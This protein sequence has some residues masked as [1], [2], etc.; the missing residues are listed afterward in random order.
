MIWVNGGV[1]LTPVTRELGFLD[2]RLERPAA[3]LFAA[4][5]APPVRPRPPGAMLA[6]NEGDES[7]ADRIRD[8]V[9]ALTPPQEQRINT[10]FG[11]WRVPRTDGG[12]K[13]SC[14]K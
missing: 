7:H 12:S 11:E 13:Y 3:L 14:M 9:P 8:D 5:T 1:G 6:A 10:L 4:R 2:H